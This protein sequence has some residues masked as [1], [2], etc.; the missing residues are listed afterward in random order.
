[1]QPN[2]SEPA[3]TA[4]ARFAPLLRKAG[5]RKAW[6]SRGGGVRVVEWEKVCPDGRTLKCQIWADG[7][8]RIS[9]EWKGCMDTLPTDF[10]DEGGL[11]VAMLKESNRIDSRH[12]AAKVTRHDR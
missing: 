2:K 1:M 3:M 11:Y 7:N 8:H 12:Y 9:H 4:F 10:T 6:D 5:F